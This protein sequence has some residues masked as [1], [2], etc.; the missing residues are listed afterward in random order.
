[1]HI[2]H[3]VTTHVIYWPRI[4]STAQIAGYADRGGLGWKLNWSQIDIR[5]LSAES[6]AW[7]QIMRNERTLGIEYR[8]LVIAM[9]WCVCFLNYADRQAVF[10]IFPL[11][12]SE[13][14]LS[15]VQLGIIGAAFMWVYA[16]FGPITGWLGDRLQR[17]TLILGGLTLWLLVTGA[18]I[19]S[20]TYA[21]L[22]VLRAI[23][24]LSEAFYFPAAMSLISDYHGS[25]TRSRSMSFHQSAVYVG[26]VAGG[27]GGALVAQHY[28]NWR[29]NFVMLGCVGVFLIVVLLIGL[30]EPVRGQAEPEEYIAAQARL[31]E[32]KRTIGDGL[33]EIFGNPLV[34]LFIFVFMGANFVAVVF[35]V[36]MPSFLYRKFN[37]SLSMAGLNGTFFLQ[38]ASVAG[39]ISG[40]WLADTLARRGGKGR[41]KTQAIGL[42]AG[43]PFILLAGWTFSIPLLI[44]G[45]IGF[46]YCKG[47]YDANI[48]ASLYDVVPIERRSAAAGIVNSL[49]W[50]GGGV[51][52]IAI[53]AAS[54]RFGM[55]ACISATSMIYLIVGALLLWNANA[56]VVA[57]KKPNAGAALERS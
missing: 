38:L 35:L 3:I 2:V 17:R 45:M 49:G 12:K 39:V 37:M 10:A 47:I 1:M 44:V 50:L 31:G 13:L 57:S 53:A 11:L 54:Y 16:A 56:K 21:Q 18:T 19:L 30:R 48:F 6:Y 25:A 9:L 22:A 42:L 8:W 27:A 28:H 52:P 14:N 40:G 34:R 55:S 33:R 20:H 4:C 43:V 15:D 46:G 23:G 41:M 32:S 7:T 24:G 5:T 26:T 36:W 29:A 51:A